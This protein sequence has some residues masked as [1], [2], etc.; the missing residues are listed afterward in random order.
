[1]SILLGF[2]LILLLAIFVLFLYC[3][4]VLSEYDNPATTKELQRQLKIKDNYLHSIYAIGF[5]NGDY[6]SIKVLRDT[7][8]T[9][10]ELSDKAL[11]CDDNYIIGTNRN[12]GEEYNILME[13]R[14]RK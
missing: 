13:V 9:M 5:D 6:T 10:V 1:M 7:I 8:D 4:R 14:K 3:A 11:N 12:T 2:V